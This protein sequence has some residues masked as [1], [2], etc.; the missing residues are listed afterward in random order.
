MEPEERPAP[1]REPALMKA[2]DGNRYSR[3]DAKRAARGK[4][5]G[6]RVGAVLL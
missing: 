3:R 6:K 5:K 2:N 4:K 1:M